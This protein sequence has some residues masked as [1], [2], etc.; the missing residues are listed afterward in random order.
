M[1]RSDTRGVLRGRGEKKHIGR[2]E[3]VLGRP[4][5]RAELSESEKRLPLLLATSSSFVFPRDTRP[6]IWFCVICRHLVYPF[7]Y[8]L[9][10][11]THT[12][13]HEGLVAFLGGSRP[14]PWFLCFLISVIFFGSFPTFFQHSWR[15][16]EMFLR[17][18]TLV[19]LTC[20]YCKIDHFALGVNVLYVV[21][22]LNDLCCIFL[23]I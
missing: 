1:K 17:W 5:N 3:G 2:E 4:E 23:V 19:N 18:Q 11:H 9:S 21:F 22:H 10:K 7:F 8:L 15:F 20:D 16:G 6:I 13:T 14:L 12:R